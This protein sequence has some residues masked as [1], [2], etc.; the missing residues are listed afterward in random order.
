MGGSR[1]GTTGGPGDY[2]L[3][4]LEIKPTIQEQTKTTR[5]WWT[6]I[7][8]TMD[9]WLPLVLIKNLFVQKKLTQDV[10]MAE[11][12]IFKFVGKTDQLEYSEFYKIFCKGIF[13]VA[14]QDMMNNIEKLSKDQEDLPLPL[15]LAAYRR[16]LMLSGIDKTESDLKERGKSILYAMKI[17]KSELDPALF[18]GLDFKEFVMDPLGFNKKMTGALYEEKRL[19]KYEQTVRFNRVKDQ[20][21]K[22][23]VDTI[24]I[25]KQLRG[26]DDQT[27]REVLKDIQ[28]EKKGQQ[29]KQQP[30]FDV[31]RL[32]LQV[33]NEEEKGGE[34]GELSDDDYS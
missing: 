14:L 32:N 34:I 8:P 18:E 23:G 2:A 26:E 12:I 33:I 29:F 7:N 27:I 4:K 10:D 30:K 13:K 3:K 24:E 22:I 17:Y 20:G 19:K 16:S 11:K 15:K 25:E 31:E 9:I 21:L 6:S 28:A 5:D 1:F